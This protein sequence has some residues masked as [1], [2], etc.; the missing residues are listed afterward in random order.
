MSE[1]KYIEGQEVDIVSAMMHKTVKVVFGPSGPMCDYWV[2]DAAGEN[3]FRTEAQIRPIPVVTFTE[4]QMEV[5]R[6]A[7][8]RQFPNF[9]GSVDVALDALRRDHSEKNQPPTEGTGEQ[10]GS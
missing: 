10:H 3:Y 6:E 2:R 9:K 7:L 1:P 5:V 4:A 8:Y